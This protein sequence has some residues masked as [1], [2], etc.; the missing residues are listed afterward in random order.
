[1]ASDGDLKAHER[2]YS[3]FTTLLKWAT[4]AAFLTGLIVIFVISN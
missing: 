2:T 3:G 1:M 4:I